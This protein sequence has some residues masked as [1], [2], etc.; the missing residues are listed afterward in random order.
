MGDFS[1]FRF[2]CLEEIASG[3]PIG[4]VAVAGRLGARKRSPVAQLGCSTSSQTVGA[5]AS[6]PQVQLNAGG[7]PA[8]RKRTGV[9]HPLARCS[10]D[11]AG[12]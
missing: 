1:W 2:A 5:R 9:A 8:Q 4:F 12:G 3:V 6:R 10:S 11:C 7:T